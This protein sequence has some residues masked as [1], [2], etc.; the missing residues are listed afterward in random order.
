MDILLY[1]K[2]WGGGYS[3]PPPPRPP[4]SYTSGVCVYAFVHACNTH[5]HITQLL[6]DSITPL[7]QLIG[8]VYPRKNITSVSFRHSGKG[9]KVEFWKCEPGAACVW[10][11]I[12]S[13]PKGGT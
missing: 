11:C 3:L 2:T 1:P 7:L 8:D 12:F 9:G 5:T 4:A 10:Q 6:S 13:N